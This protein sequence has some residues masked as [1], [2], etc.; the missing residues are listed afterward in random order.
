MYLR[1]FIS[2]PY[3]YMTFVIIMKI[4]EESD[5]HI[6]DDYLFDLEQYNF[7]INRKTAL[8]LDS[9]VVNDHDKLGY[10]LKSLEAIDPVLLQ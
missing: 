2:L 10:I 4:L 1:D 8:S 3:S 5:S 6:N 9:A 7:I